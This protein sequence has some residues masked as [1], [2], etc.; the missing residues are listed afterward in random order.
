M[1]V[2]YTLVTWLCV[3]NNQVSP[4]PEHPLHIHIRN[5]PQAASLYGGVMGA[6]SMRRAVSSRRDSM[7]W[8]YITRLT[9]LGMATSYKCFYWILVC[10]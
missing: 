6:S 7:A 2:M 10:N 3:D 1:Y 5:V 8:P 4:G 9:R